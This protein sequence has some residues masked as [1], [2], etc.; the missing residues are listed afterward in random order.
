MLLLLIGEAY[1]SAE[2]PKINSPYGPTI[3]E[4][5][6]QV[7][8]KFDPASIPKNITAPYNHPFSFTGDEMD[9]V[10]RS[11]SY[12]ARSNADGA[13]KEAQPVFSNDVIS[14]LSGKLRDAFSKAGKNDLI[15]FQVWKKK[16]KTTG[17]AFIAGEKIY[18]KFGFINGL[19]F[20]SLAPATASIEEGPAP[21][22]NWRLVPGD[23]QSSSGSPRSLAVHLDYFKIGRPASDGVFAGNIESPQNLGEGKAQAVSSYK[24][25]SQG[26]MWRKGGMDVMYFKKQETGKTSSEYGYKVVS[27]GLM[28]RGKPTAPGEELKAAQAGLTE[29]PVKKPVELLISA[30]AEGITPGRLEFGQGFDGAVSAEDGVKSGNALLN[31]YYALKKLRANNGISNEEYR[32][33]RKELIL[34]QGTPAPSEETK[35]AGYAKDKTPDEFH[36]EFKGEYE[37]DIPDRFEGFNRAMYGLNDF[38]YERALEPVANVYKGVTDDDLRMMVKNFF[39]N[40]TMPVQLIS[41]LLQLEGKKAGR[42]LSRFFINTT[43]TGGLVDVAK[44]EFHIDRVDANFDQVLEKLGMDTGPYVVWP[45]SGPAT[46]RSTVGMVVDKALSPFWLFGFGLEPVTLGA[47]GGEKINDTALSLGFKEEIDDMAVDPYLSVRDLY[48]QHNQGKAA[49]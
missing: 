23:G 10:L 38:I 24:P 6:V 25:V 32:K 15:F 34:R 22:T 8:N 40:L 46:A 43:L 11:L 36:V 3:S 4:I 1:P 44:T 21:L 45:L 28:W 33:K 2:T 29:E 17:L 26:V 37:K 41:S 35:L 31:E 9:S 13:L 18:W 12:S 49:D 27:E 42:S 7:T 48:L 47:G 16:Y 5:S 19:P 30:K 39:Y 20:E 14:G